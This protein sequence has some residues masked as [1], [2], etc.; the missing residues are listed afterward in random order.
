MQKPRI[1]PALTLIG[2]S[3]SLL[4]AADHQLDARSGEK[5][6]FDLRSGGDIEVRGWDR[7]GASITTEI[8]GRDADRLHVSVA[9]TANGIKISTPSGDRDVRASV[10]IKAQVPRRYDVEISTMG[11]DVRLEELE[12]EFSGETMGGDIVLRGLSGETTISTMGGDIS[13]HDSYLDGEVSTMGGDVELAH[14]EGNL[15]ASTMG[16]DV[17][18]RDVRR[19]AGSGATEVKIRSHGGDVEVDTAPAGADVHT[20]G[21]DITVQS[22]DEFLRA[23][24]MGGDIEVRR[25]TGNADLHTMGGDIEVESFDGEIQAITMGGDVEVRV[26]GTASPGGHG[27][28]LDSMGGDLTLVLPGDFSGRFEVELVKLRKHEDQARIVSD[29]PLDIDEPADWTPGNR[30]DDG[31]RH[32]G[33]HKIIRASGA[34]GGGDHL[35]KLKTING[36]VRIVR[37]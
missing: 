30:R 25:A 19:S 15:D 35:V 5:L 28:M 29:F 12:G 37:R 36:V 32:G 3:A 23:K 33:D 17:T 10:L 7:E 34:V 21:G 9:R 16:G 27:V 8:T 2:L 26:D 11:G 1:F 14:V 31:H 20:M 18:Q 13:V 6:I 4:L 24:T 22:A